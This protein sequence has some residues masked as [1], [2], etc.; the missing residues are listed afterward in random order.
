MSSTPK[1]PAICFFLFVVALS[2]ATAAPAPI[3]SATAPYATV[4]SIERLDPALDALLP[5]DA[6]MEKL[7]EGF[8]WS[9]GP[10]WMKPG[11][12]LLFSDVPQ[13]RVYC[14][15]DS[16]GISVFLEPS[17][18]TGTNYD[19]R[20][21][22]S[23]GLTFDRQGRLAL[24]QQGDRRIAR[25]AED[26]KSF[27]TLADRWEGKRFNSPNDLCFDRAGNLYFTD[28]PYGMGPST[29]H[30]L[31]FFGVF[32]LGVDGKLTVVTRDLVRP[33]GIALSPDEH[34][35]YV[36]S[37][38]APSPFIM[39]YP[40]RADGTNGPGTV[41]FDGTGLIA[42]THRS[43]LMDGMKVDTQGNLWATGP[44]GVLI[45]NSAGKHLGTLLTGGPTANCAFG[46][47]DGRTLFIM[48]GSRLLRIKT[49]VTDAGR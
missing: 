28:P 42:R 16:E 15:R 30:E 5:A 45:I 14:W 12:Q 20:E 19:G 10:V 1:G 24:C 29:S 27:V 48:S 36:G 35:L 2:V 23:N 6:K 49:N 9:E 34:T 8:T 22:G 13:N 47:A 18:F 41:F 33:N 32:R 4:G 39:A 3:I 17:G 43:G 7:A 44:G 37:T 46:G 11:A 40:L 31:D 21:R 38:D 26:G 25:L